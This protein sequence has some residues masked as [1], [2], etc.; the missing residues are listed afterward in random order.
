MGGLS[1]GPWSNSSTRPAPCSRATRPPPRGRR[2]CCRRSPS[3]PAAR[4]RYA[5]R[6]PPPAPP[7]TFT[8]GSGPTRRSKTRR[9]AARPTTR[10]PRR[11]AWTRPSSRWIPPEPPSGAA[12]S[13]AWPPAH[14]TSDDWYS[15]TA[16]AGEPMTVAAAH[17]GSGGNEAL[18]LY[19]QAGN[20]LAT[21]GGKTVYTDSTIPNFVTP[22]AGTYYVRVSGAAR[23]D[24][25]TRHRARGGL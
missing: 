24:V 3:R 25:P 21:G 6:M 19:D 10:S 22:A 18:S 14:S 20:L 13:A 12:S 9:T 11:R 4:I 16:G 5:Y 7:G 17:Q 2:G 8:S 1:S 23:H 15:F